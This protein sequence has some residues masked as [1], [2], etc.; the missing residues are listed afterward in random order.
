MAGAGTGAE[1]QGWSRGIRSNRQGLGQV[2]RGQEDEDSRAG[3][4]AEGQRDGV[5]GWTEG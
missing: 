5:K 3:A 2:A 4:G 1:C